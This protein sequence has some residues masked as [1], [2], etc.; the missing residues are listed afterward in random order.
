MGN[1]P[2]PSTPAL[3]PLDE[4]K[5]YLPYLGA[6]KYI[7]NQFWGVGQDSYTDPPAQNPS[8]FTSLNNIQPIIQGTLQRRWGY[9]LFNS[10]AAAN[11]AGN[12]AGPYILAYSYQRDADTSRRL[13]FWQFGIPSAFLALNEDGSLYGVVGTPATGATIPRCLTSRDWLYTLAFNVSNNLFYK[14]NGN[15][16]PAAPAVT[17]SGGGSV[18]GSNTYQVAYEDAAG[19]IY[20]ASP[21]TPLTSSSNS[22]VITSPPAM[23]GMTK[24][25]VYVNGHV[26]G[27]PTNLGTNTTLSSVS[28]SGNAPITYQMVPWGFPA[29]TAAPTFTTGSGSVTLT[30]GRKYFSVGY[31]TVTGHVSDLSPVSLTTGPLTNAEINL[32]ITPS[33]Q[34]F[35]DSNIILATADGGSEEVLFEVTILPRGTTTYTDNTPEL[36]LEAAN[37]YL[38]QDQY[39]N[40]FG[41]AENTPPPVG[42]TSI[43]KSVGRLFGIFGELVYF[44]KNIAEV[45]TNTGVVAGRY[46][47]C[48]PAVNFFDISEHAETARALQTDGT[49]TYIGSERRVW[50]L[51]GTAPSSATGTP[52]QLPQV[53]FNDVGVLNQ[54]V[55]QICFK[56]GQPVGAIWLTPDFRIIQ[57]D[58][59]TYS[60][61]GHPIQDVL[62]SINTTYANT[63]NAM[64]ASSGSFDLY[65]LAVPTGSN[66][67]PD[68]LLVYNLRSGKW[69][70]WT[71]TDITTC[72]LYNITGSTSGVSINAGIPQFLFGSFVGPIYEYLSGLS[73]DRV[74]N[75]PVDF[76]ATIKTSWLDMG[77]PT[78]RKCLNELEVITGDTAMTITVEAASLQSDFASPITVVSNLA[79]ATGPLG[80]L[81]AFLAQYSTRNRYYRFT[82]SSPN[83]STIINLL[84][85]FAAETVPF[86]RL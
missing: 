19:N 86:H 74:N 21:T 23:L 46:E 30:V 17:N 7:Q 32:T 25:V 53:L 33:P 8:M 77:D 26:Q 70:V 29:P 2:T 67:N 39:G 22:V 78:V 56:E 72:Q 43:I 66:Q 58:F 11:F 62:F 1:T 83:T 34:S 40:S 20:Q 54:E 64:Y 44:S 37:T 3:T 55:W 85:G 76:P 6:F 15:V 57:S 81:K 10:G 16:A 82:F 60:D 36:T 14:W 38:S 79:L 51:T 52:F 63:A 75:T 71:P 68:T 73:S 35:A 45:T 13:V 65:M 59:N 41:C 12:L 61:I 5:K 80:E 69:V 48:W 49:Y 18:S 9:E 24:Y 31:S 50:R 28:G 47:E 27:S 4:M 84:E 42:L